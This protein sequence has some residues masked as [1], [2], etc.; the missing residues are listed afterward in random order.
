MAQL[1]K[2]RQNLW[3]YEVEYPDFAVRGALVLGERY[4][5]V[6]D[7]LTHPSDVAALSD[8]L[9]EKPFYLVYSHADWDH[10]WGTNGFRQAPAAIVG[11]A[12]CRRRFDDE[13][14]TTLRQM[15][16]E[17]E[18]R[19]ETVRLVPPNLSF[20]KALSL[21]LGGVTLELR[22]LPGHSLDCIVGWIPEWG[23]LLGGDTFETPLPV[24]NHVEFLDEWLADLETWAARD[25]LRQTIPAHGSC[26][27]RAALTQSIAYLR[28]LS[29]DR[30]FDLPAPLDTFYAETHQKNLAAVDGKLDRNG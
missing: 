10:C 16:L 18:G 29:G 5:A 8:V 3:V 7:S 17:E 12:E 24:V 27:G 28:A 2:I 21:D 19:W 26:S 15:Q 1:Q 4:A 13:A 9:G 25:D 11:H 6:W 23:V 30:N 22:H 20:T 14:P